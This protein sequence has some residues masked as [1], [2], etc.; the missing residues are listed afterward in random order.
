MTGAIRQ[1]IHYSGRVQG[2]GF[3]YTTDRI[4]KDFAVTGYVKNRADGRVELVVEGARGEVRSFTDQIQLTMANNI[5][6]TDVHNL[7]ATG[8]FASFNIDF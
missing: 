5:Q 8:E 6:H 7:E 2:V 4:A 3:R 1:L